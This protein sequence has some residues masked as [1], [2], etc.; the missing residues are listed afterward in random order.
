[1]NI[2]TI[3][4]N[5]DA[6]SLLLLSR[7]NFNAGLE[8]MKKLRED[9]KKR[10][11]KEESDISGYTSAEDEFEKY[12]PEQAKTEPLDISASLVVASLMMAHEVNGENLD[13]LKRGLRTP[14]QIVVS[15]MD[16]MADQEA[17]QRMMTA[18]KFGLT[19]SADKF[20]AQIKGKQQDQ[21]ASFV[22]EAQSAVNT[23]LRAME[24]RHLTHLLEETYTRKTWLKE[25]QDNAISLYEAAVK[26]LEDGK[27]ADLP[28]EIVT[29][30]QDALEAR[31]AAA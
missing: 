30:A 18:Q 13:F 3:L 31:K 4:A 11:S 10:D 24:Y 20:L 22:T 2:K 8:M 19:V 15:Q 6:V 29:F 16:W 28:D 26:R 5:R 14:K 27:F 23:G 25:L 1:M 17:K 21:I 7:I 9:Q 12:T